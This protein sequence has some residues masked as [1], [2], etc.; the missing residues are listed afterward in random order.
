M[1]IIWDKADWK[2]SMAS[3][4]IE[5][6][7][8]KPQV[9]DKH[10]IELSNCSKRIKNLPYDPTSWK[11]R[12]NI[13]YQLWFPEL[14]I[15][16]AYKGI[17]LCNA[18]INNDTRCQDVLLHFGVA[19]WRKRMNKKGPPNAP[20]LKEVL[21]NMEYRTWLEGEKSKPGYEDRNLNSLK[22]H[23]KDLYIAMIGALIDLDATREGLKIC[24]EALENYPTNKDFLSFK[25]GFAA[26]YSM[27][28]KLA[29]KQ[30]PPA[31]HLFLTL[32]MGA[33]SMQNYPW[34]PKDMLE[35]GG[36][37]IT[38]CNEALLKRSE[39]LEIKDSGLGDY[40]M[41]AKKNIRLGSKLLSRQCPINISSKQMR[42]PVEDAECFNCCQ[43][44]RATGTVYAIEC[45]PT[46]IY[47]STA[48]QA[49]AKAY[50]HQ[51]LH[52]KDYSQL[53]RD[54]YGAK[55]LDHSPEFTKLVFLRMLATC[56]QGGGHPL[57]NPLFAG[58]LPATGGR[59]IWSLEG[60]IIGP[61]KI[62]EDFGI[63]IFANFDYDAW[64]ATKTQIP[65]HAVFWIQCI[66]SSTTAVKFLAWSLSTIRS[67]T[68]MRS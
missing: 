33:L 28:S 26:T 20:V 6:D 46:V 32:D 31:L 23:R 2:P 49:I 7:A 34:I 5:K 8:P 53:Y 3:Q 67:G 62:L 50:Y 17:S 10:I 58:L 21:E 66:H 13:L 36:D 35:R 12:S 1:D 14:A 37:V 40:G 25:E 48:C 43:A 15:S 68:L 45:C 22:G 9:L 60:N 61:N 16:D 41:F 55:G 51:A 44:I 24:D 38:T 47:C 59:G 4:F 29:K 56:V 65:L 42:T 27:V 57:K 52:G 19:A 63:D 18:A 39:V 64:H 11:A 54:S 30:N